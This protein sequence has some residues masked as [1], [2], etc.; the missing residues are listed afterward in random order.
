MQ[1]TLNALH[2]NTDV[3]SLKIFTL[4]RSLTVSTPESMPN[5]PARAKPRKFPKPPAQK[6]IPNNGHRASLIPFFTE[7]QSF[8]FSLATFRRF[9]EAGE[10]YQT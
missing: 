5:T 1:L 4:Q 7:S 2:L 6:N 8:L 10:G 3:Q 9:D